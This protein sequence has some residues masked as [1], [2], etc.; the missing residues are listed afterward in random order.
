MSN[1]YKSEQDACVESA[2]G[3][4]KKMFTI[5]SIIVA[6]GIREK[7]VSL[8]QMLPASLR[9]RFFLFFLGRLMCI[10][11]AMYSS[12]GL[13]PEHLP[14]SKR[15]PVSKVRWRD[16]EADVEREEKR[17]RFKRRKSRRYP[18]THTQRE[19]DR[20][21]K[22]IEME[23]VEKKEERSNVQLGEQRTHQIGGVGS[24]D[25]ECCSCCCCT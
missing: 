22:N 11:W 17:N 4:S 12:C 24:L 1:I 13:Q 10:C 16:I 2:A 5:L 23:N 8:F 7:L 25:F 19:R 15:G 20:H 14:G 21:T 6:W 18:H 9:Y 3:P